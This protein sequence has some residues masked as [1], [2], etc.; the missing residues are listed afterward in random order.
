MKRKKLINK[1]SKIITNIARAIVTKLDK[2]SG[3]HK[4]K[5]DQNCHSNN[6]SSNCHSSSSGCH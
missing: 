6:S 5:A 4:T 3:C 1:K 2:E